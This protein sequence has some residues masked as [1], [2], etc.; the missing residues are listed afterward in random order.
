M[1]KN[2]GDAPMGTNMHV[3]FKEDNHNTCQV[4]RLLSTADADA[5]AADDAGAAAAGD[6]LRNNISPT[7]ILRGYN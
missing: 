3:K 7:I 6:I 1:N 4:I 2:R 5:A